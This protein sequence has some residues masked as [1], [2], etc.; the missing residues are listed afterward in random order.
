MKTRFVLLTSCNHL[1]LYGQEISNIISIKFHSV[2][3]IQELSSSTWCAVFGTLLQKAQDILLGKVEC[4]M[5]LGRPGC[6]WMKSKC[7]ARR[8]V[9]F[10]WLHI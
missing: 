1:I 8:W 9:R 3:D 2:L 10:S 5:P 4:I 7:V 6:R